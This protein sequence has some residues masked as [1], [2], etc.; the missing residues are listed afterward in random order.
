MLLVRTTR[1]AVDAAC[2]LSERLGR[3]DAK[4]C[5]VS[6][7]LGS[8]LDPGSLADTN[9]PADATVCAVSEH[10]GPLLDPGFLAGTNCPVDAT[11]CLVV[12]RPTMF[13]VQ[14][15]CGS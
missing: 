14:Q 1:T 2:A 7:R 13:H 9:C 8:L 3:A 15:S 11:P 12:S 6:K 4:A 5:A 10:L